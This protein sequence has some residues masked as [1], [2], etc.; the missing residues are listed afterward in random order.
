MT[1][2][3]PVALILVALAAA[4]VGA[5]LVAGI[6]SSLGFPLPPSHRRM[7]CADGLRG[8]L[9]LFVMAHHFIIWFRVA[10]TGE[11][12]AEPTVAA[13]NSFGTGGVALFFMTTG[14]VFY[15]R[16]LTGFRKTAWF[17]VL[18]TRTFRIVPL[19]AVST[20]MAGLIL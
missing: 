10:R 12:W 20:A 17:A 11:P 19:V 5:T 9:A 1:F 15:P 3:Y 4:L 2:T 7:G 6:A 8:Y 14:L 13:F 16:V 18:T